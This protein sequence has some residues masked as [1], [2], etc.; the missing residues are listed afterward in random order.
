MVMFVIVAGGCIIGLGPGEGES[1]LASDLFC[2]CG[3]CYD[4]DAF[5]L[6]PE[7]LQKRSAPL[8]KGL[9][10]LRAQFLLFNLA[11]HSLRG[12][13]IGTLLKKSSMMIGLSNLHALG[14]VAMCSQINMMRSFANASF[15][16]WGI[17]GASLM[18]MM[19]STGCAEFAKR[20][21]N[22]I[23]GSLKNFQE[24][25]R[26]SLKMNAMKKDGS[27]LKDVGAG[28]T[29]AHASYIS[30]HVN[31]SPA[32]DSHYN[33]LRRCTPVVQRGAL[34]QSEPVECSIHQAMLQSKPLS[35]CSGHHKL[36]LQP[37]WS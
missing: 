33:L 5:Y 7:W 18:M 1:T 2:A 35:A 37:A 34:L 29:S 10:A 9:P 31:V 23:L 8:L 11:Q 12:S 19:G 15:H 30:F 22:W 21:A 32:N 6:Q 13:T 20:S 3:L 14:K 28:I 16:T 36:R 25:S 27:D 17:Q 24:Q 4:V 26:P